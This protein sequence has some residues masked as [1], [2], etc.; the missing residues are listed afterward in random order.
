[1]T[2]PIYP[3]PG[4]GS[5][6]TILCIWTTGF[7]IAPPYLYNMMFLAPL[8][9][10]LSGL[11]SQ[12]TATWPNYVVD[13]LEHLLVDTDR[14]NDAGFQKAITP[15]QNYVNGS[16]LLG[17]E[18][19]AQGVRVAFHDFVTANVQAGTGG[20]DASIGFETLRPENSG[21]AMNDS[22]AFFAPFVNAEVSMA[23]MIALSI[24]MVVGTC[25]SPSIAVPLRGGRV[26]AT[27][28]GP[29][30]VPEPETDIDTTLNQFSLAGFNQEDAIGLTVCGHT[31]GSVHHAG[32]PQVVPESAVTLNNTGGGVHFDATPAVFDVDVLREY[33]EGNGQR[34]GPLVTTDNI[35]VRSDL[36]LYLSDNNATLR[37]LAESDSKFISTCVSLLER[38]IDT[39]PSSVHLTDDIVPQELKPINI[40]LAVDADGHVQFN[41]YI[42]LLS[43]A[44]NPTDKVQISWRS[45]GGASSPAFETSASAA[46][47]GN[48]SMFGTTFYH[49]FNTTID[50]TNG[51]STFDVS[52][53]GPSSS[54][55]TF[56]NGGVG[57]P[58]EDLAIFLSH[59]TTIAADG[60]LSVHAAVLTSADVL[61]VTAVVSAPSPQIG[62]LSPTIA[63]SEVI[64]EA[65]GT[66]GLYTLYGAQVPAVTN[67]QQTTAELIAYGPEGDVYRDTFRRISH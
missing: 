44:F 20:I 16:Q 54:A 46:S 40:S 2:D 35:T 47:M 48:S 45:R 51:I 19:A 15:C 12:V 38:M 4:T 7:A 55:Q 57:Y 41:G 21:A 66:R 50:P 17:R 34:G 18:T 59:E 14:F 60:T 43:T 8:L 5:D 26:D 9:I 33:L 53:L 49:F 67:V 37:G 58:I 11:Y 63:K 32:F 24:V 28:A 29:F 27:E 30:G 13:E 25:S 64:L 22:L 61:N 31:L 52:V 39:I 23:D 1:M 62:T 36:R 56:S 65:V 6:S 3:D 10:F 42:R